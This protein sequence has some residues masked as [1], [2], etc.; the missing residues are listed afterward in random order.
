[1]KNSVDRHLAKLSILIWGV[2]GLFCHKN[3]AQVC[4][5]YS[6]INQ[7]FMGSIS[8]PPV[9]F[10]LNITHGIMNCVHIIFHMQKLLEII[11][12]GNFLLHS[13]IAPIKVI[14]YD[15]K[16]NELIW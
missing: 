4:I 9:I 10:W 14:M 3:S 15:Q 11:L 5:K 8:P 16:F 1:M 7:A 6:Y 2:G 13:I 12:F